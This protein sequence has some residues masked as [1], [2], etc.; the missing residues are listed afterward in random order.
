MTIGF[1]I[2]IYLCMWFITL[3]A[4]LPF[5]VRTQGEAG[6]IVPGTPESAPQAF[7]FSRVVLVNTLVATVCFAIFYVGYTQN[8]LDLHANRPPIPLR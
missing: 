4:V 3:F 1:A 2:A 6:D 7:R 5:G 8:W